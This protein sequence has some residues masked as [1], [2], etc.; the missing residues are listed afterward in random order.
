[1]NNIEKKTLEQLLINCK[2][3][4]IIG[5]PAI[6]IHH[7]TLN[8]QNIQT[9]KEH[10]CALFAAIKG[11]T[12]DGHQY[13]EKA[14]AAGAGAVLCEQLPPDLHPNITY[15]QVEKT[16]EA[17]GNI[18]KV[19]FNNPTEKL[20]LVGVTGTNGKTSIVTLLH[21]LFQKLGYRVGLLSTIVNK[22]DHTEIAATHTTPD[23][24]SL[25]LLLSQMVDAGCEFAFMEVSS[26]AL[27]Q[28]R[29]FGLTFAGA[30]FSNITRDH[31]DYHL[32]FSKYIQA[33]KNFFDGLNHHAFALSNLDDPNGEIMLQNTKALSFFYS[34]R[35][36]THFKAKVLENSFEG[37]QLS[38]NDEVFFTHLIG[39]FN[40][41]N[42]LAVYAAAQ[43]LLNQK[44]IDILTPLSGL[45]KP[46]GRFEHLKSPSGIQIIIDYAHTPDALENVLSTITVL[47]KKPAKIITVFGCGGNRDKGK[48]P[49]MAA[50]AEKYSDQLIFTSD[51]PRHENANEIL[52]DMM[53]GLKNK[54]NF[55]I[56]EV[57]RRK[58]IQIAYQMAQKDD[59]ILI[60]GKG[61]ENYQ[62]I[63]DHKIIFSDFE[64]A[65]NTFKL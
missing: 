48:R 41:Y 4:K 45:N 46:K 29:I 63:G 14:I 55:L 26:H 28:N 12:Q 6:F 39:I 25:H 44:S 59:I 5:N 15:I 58:A 19:F 30:I 37:M 21:Q 57:D 52:E 11:H 27:D 10:F 33:K 50:V 17:L 62:I 38:F 32:T 20:K 13:I 9:S 8:S 65:L 47:R 3:I 61:H 43:L 24:I 31:L 51:N 42:L 16:T 34:L 2:T 64:T 56:C 49:M 1:M 7:I 53:A 40:A 54:H 35:T 60:A 22:I 18:C 23:I 36:K